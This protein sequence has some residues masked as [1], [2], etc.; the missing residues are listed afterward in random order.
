MKRFFPVDPRHRWSG[1]PAQLQHV[2][3]PGCVRRVQV[4]RDAT[5]RHHVSHSRRGLRNAAS[6]LEGAKNPLALGKAHAH[7]LSE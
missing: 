5:G 3:V 7:S 1:R 2:P 4:L 6:H